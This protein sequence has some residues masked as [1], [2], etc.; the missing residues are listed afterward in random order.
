MGATVSGNSY[1][2]VFLTCRKKFKWKDILGLQP[3]TLDKNQETGSAAHIG[4]AEW[5]ENH[6]PKV[7][8]DKAKAYLESVNMSQEWDIT[9]AILK[10]YFNKFKNS[11]LQLVIPEFETS[12]KIGSWTYTMKIDGIAILDKHFYLLEHKTSGLGSSLFFRKFQIDR[13]ITGYMLG[14]QQACPDKEIIGVF[15]NGLFKPKRN[16]GGLG[17]VPEP[18]RELFLRT[19]EQFKVFK[20]DTEAI[21]TEIENCKLA[22][23]RGLDWFY[24]NTEACVNFNRVCEYME[25]CKYGPLPELIEALFKSEKKET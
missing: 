21:F 2:S 13:Q 24:Q 11:Q 6:I 25:L 4:L 8:L 1:L 5:H 15:V 3:N 10:A 23:D 7:A 22:L 18:E 19:E 16:K 12:I 20:E 9:E 17:Q 14:A